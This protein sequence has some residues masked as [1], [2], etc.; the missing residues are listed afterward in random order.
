[1]SRC[2][3][4]PLKKCSAPSSMSTPSRARSRSAIHVNSCRRRRKT[5]RWPKPANGSSRIASSAGIT[6]HAVVI[7][8]GVAGSWFVGTDQIVKNEPA[9]KV[10]AVDTTG[11][12]DVFHGAYAAALALGATL[13][14]CVRLAAAAAALKATQ[15][16]GQRG[17]PTRIQ[18]DEFLRSEPEIL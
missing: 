10:R 2:C 6:C 15:P 14:E 11:C 13:N 8:C 1:M 12:G 4:C 7:T 17:I 18:V 16:G 9:F 5:R 3:A